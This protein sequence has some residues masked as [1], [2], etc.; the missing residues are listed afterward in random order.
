MFQFQRKR[1]LTFSG[2]CHQKLV[3]KSQLSKAQLSKAKLSKS[4]N[5][6]QTISLIPNPWVQGTKVHANGIHAK[7]SDFV[8][9]ISFPCRLPARRR[10]CH[11]TRCDVTKI[12]DLPTSRIT[13]SGSLL[14]SLFNTQFFRRYGRSNLCSPF[15]PRFLS[16][17]SSFYIIRIKKQ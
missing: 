10:M 4:P 14:F 5:L 7:E 8:I 17:D 15:W 13:E 6:Q 12:L 1:N 2:S 11:V 3:I 16:R 9:P